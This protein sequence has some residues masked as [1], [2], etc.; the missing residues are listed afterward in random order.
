MNS[1]AASSPLIVVA[2]DDPQLLKAVQ[3]RLEQRNFRVATAASKRDLYEILDGEPPALLLL[4]LFFGPVDGLDLLQ[5]LRSSRPNLN[6]VMFSSQGSIDTAVS[7]IKF[8]AFDFLTKPHDYNRLVSIIQH[9][10]ERS[11]LQTRVEHLERE[12]AAQATTRPL[13]GVSPPME[14][15]RE[16][17]ADVARTDAT[18]LILGA[19]GTGK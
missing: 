15:L 4:D 11:V 9:A 19:S 3:L 2:D 12:V 10:R 18:V 6:V 7:A 14:R 13:L 17:I 8:G 16:L 1:P 5:E